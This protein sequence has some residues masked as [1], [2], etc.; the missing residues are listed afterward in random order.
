MDAEAAF[1]VVIAV[2]AAR[3]YRATQAGYS[4]F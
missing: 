1:V 4:R 3:G 2:V